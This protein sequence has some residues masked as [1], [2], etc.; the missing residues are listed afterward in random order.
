MISPRTPLLSAL[1]LLSLATPARATWSIVVVDQ[2]TGEVG[3]GGATCVNNINLKV[4]LPAIRVGVGAGVTQAFVNSSASNKM[5]IFNELANGT[6][7]ATI[8]SLIQAADS[9]F[10]SR[11]IGIVD[12][13]G[14]KISFTGNNAMQWKGGLTG[15]DGSLHYA[16]QG[17]VLT[18]EIVIKRAEAA[19]R[20]TPG[21]LADRL[22]AAMDAAK[23]FGGDGRCSCAPQNPTGCGAPPPGSWKSAHVGFLLISRQGDFDG[24]CASG[25]GCGNGSY[26]LDLNVSGNQFANPDAVVQ[27]QGQ[28]LTWRHA[29]AGRPDHLKSSLV[30]GPAVIANDGV[31]QGAVTIVPRDWTGAALGQ[32]GMTVTATSEPGSAGAVTIG[33]VVDQGNGVYTVPYTATTTAGTDR[34]RVVIDDGQGPVTLWPP[35][36]VVTAPTAFLAATP[37]VSAALGDDIALTLAGG[38][39]L[40]DRDYVVLFSAGGTQPGFSIGAVDVPLVL[41][42]LVPISFAFCGTA[43]LPGTCGP[44][45][46]NGDANGQ[47]LLAPNDLSPL[48]GGA[49]TLAAISFDPIDWVS[50]PVVVSV[51][52]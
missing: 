29:W 50:T 40:A 26:W 52:P 9:G 36:E 24:V 30:K 16:I 39:G 27:L 11:Q 17:N 38:P 37:A 15:N 48:V 34:L 28:F 6:P 31:S 23:D 18:A 51:N 22:L 8:L 20:T 7:P 33:T 47:V 43:A 21:D 12:M 10:Q 2:A 3:V 41:D 46:G 19:L 42:P 13:S 35:V 45:D 4:F 44:L 25:V 49:L 5:I 1:V 14:Q 32:A